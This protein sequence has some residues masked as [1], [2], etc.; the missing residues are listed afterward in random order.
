VQA[1]QPHPSAGRRRE[2][3]PGEVQVVTGQAGGAGGSG[4]QVAVVVNVR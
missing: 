2:W 1:V 4:R 3:N